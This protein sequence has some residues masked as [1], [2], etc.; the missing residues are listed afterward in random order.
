MF[1]KNGVFAVSL[2]SF[3]SFQIE[4]RYNQIGWGCDV[5]SLRELVLLH[6]GNL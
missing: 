1:P 3:S 2:M 5:L 6:A 4:V